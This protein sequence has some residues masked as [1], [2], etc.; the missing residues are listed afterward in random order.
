MSLLLTIKFILFLIIEL[1]YIKAEHPNE[2][3]IK[4][5]YR[6]SEHL[7]II[8][9]ASYFGWIKI[10]GNPNNIVKLFNSVTDPTLPSIGSERFA[11]YIFIM[12]F[13][14]VI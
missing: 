5:S 12:R 4:A 9:D 8:H 3:S 14:E 10:S 1:F 2:K 7:S 11:V 6:A 13:N